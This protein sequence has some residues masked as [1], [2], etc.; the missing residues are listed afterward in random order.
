MEEDFTVSST[1][2]HKGINLLCMILI[3]GTFAYL[4][5]GWSSLPDLLPA[6][7]NAAGE[8]D[9]MGSKAEIMILPVMSLILFLGIGVLERKPKIWNTGVTVTPENREFV[10]RQLKNMI[11]VVKFEIVANFT[12]LTFNSIFGKEL[13][14]VY[15]LIELLLVFGTIVFFLIRISTARKKK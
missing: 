5:L 12:Y 4:V 8:I 10:Y 13:N 1:W 3:G 2:F 7:Y 9:R 11:V 15:T 14:G 6:H